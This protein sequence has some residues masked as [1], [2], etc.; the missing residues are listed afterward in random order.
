MFYIE[1]LNLQKINKK[2]WNKKRVLITGHTGFKGRWLSMLLKELNCSV[3][4]ISRKKSSDK[5]VKS[6]N[7]DIK[8][9]VGIKKFISRVKPEIVFHLAAQPIISIS[10]ERPKETYED[11]ILGLLNILEI[12]KSQK[13]LKAIIIVTTDKCYKID[14]KSP[15][16]LN[17]LSPLGGNDPYCASKACVE[18][19]SNSYFKSFF[20]YKNI[21]LATVRAGNLVGGNDFGKD[22]IIP[23]LFNAKKNNLNVYIRNPKS[24]RPWHHVI[25]VIYGYCLLAEKL[26]IKPNKFSGSWNFAKKEKKEMKV[27]QLANIFLKEIK[28]KK[29]INF[30][31][32]SFDEQKKYVISSKKSHS[33]LG[34]KPL[35]KKEKIIIETARWYNDY[36]NNSISSD[37]LML[38]HLKKYLDNIF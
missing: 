30:Y 4:G 1:S 5:F 36:L 27:L 34:W 26:F 2:F 33:L 35:Y 17:E 13:S 20:S 16:I 8:N 18:I 32:G 31:K 38:I 29:K 37:K 14:S 22:R 12:S 9:T 6:Y 3:Y 23:D 21:G 24:S 19:I 28:Y 15:Q 7:S 25:E 11:N 10:Y